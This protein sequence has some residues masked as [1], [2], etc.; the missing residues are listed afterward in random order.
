MTRIIAI[1]NQKGGVGKTTTTLNL[2]AALKQAGRRVLCVDM[3]PQGNL[4]QAFGVNKYDDNNKYI[5][6]VMKEYVEAKDAILHLEGSDLIPC[7]IRFSGA[8]IEF[9][10]IVGR[11]QILKERLSP[12]VDDYDYILIDCPPA[13]GVI[14]LNALTF[15]TEVFTPL[16]TEFFAL[17]GVAQLTRTIEST[18][19]RV[20]HQLKLTGI[21]PTMHYAQKSLNKE[22]LEKIKDYFPGIVFNTCIRV[23]VALVESPS[24]GKNI[25]QYKPNSNGAKDYTALC[26]EVMEQEAK[27]NE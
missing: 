6:D 25:F 14:A 9:S 7:D 15:A 24:Q 23:N 2:G 26:K 1:L 19:R 12:I 17:S 27:I 21:I 13:L 18:Q 4:T 3:D 20:N 10:S 11:E 8:D 16:Q 22:V 5:Y